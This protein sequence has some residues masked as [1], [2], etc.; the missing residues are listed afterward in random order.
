[1]KFFNQD[2]IVKNGPQAKDNEITIELSHILITE[3]ND[4]LG[5]ITLNLKITSIWDEDRLLVFTNDSI[6]VDPQRIWS[7]TF[8]IETELVSKD[9]IEDDRIIAISNYNELYTEYDKFEIATAKMEKVSHIR[10]NFVCD[11]KIYS[12]PFEEHTCKLEVIF[13]I[14]YKLT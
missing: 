12:F 11:M 4:K 5:Q 14:L 7:P 13:M 8:D 9:N 3:I 10:I 2:D 6:I 1:M